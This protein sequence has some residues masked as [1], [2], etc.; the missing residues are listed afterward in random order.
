MRGIINLDF[1]DVTTV[2]KDGGVAIMSTGFGEG[3]KRVT[4]A[5]Q[6]A[7]NSPLLNNNDIYNSKKIL[8]N[9]NFCGED[10]KSELTMEEMNEVNDF[11]TKFREDVETKWGLAYDSTLGNKVKITL[12]ATGFGLGNMT[13]NCA[14]PTPKTQAE[15]D[16]EK[17]RA[18]E[19]IE[20]YYGKGQGSSNVRRNHHVFLFNEESID[21]EDVI[22]MVENLPT[23]NRTKE[24][25]KSILQ[26]N[27]ESKPSGITDEGINFNLIG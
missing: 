6:E 25:L 8:L 13:E 9:I 10:E 23:F 11:M 24:G 7:L 19:R 2:L 22:S 3:E 17:N 12:L 20:E 5:I 15:V 21:D 16:D 1:Q 27:S 4:K 26:K 18:K 14:P